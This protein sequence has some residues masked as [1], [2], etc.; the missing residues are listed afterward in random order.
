[1]HG[2][3]YFNEESDNEDPR[4]KNSSLSSYDVQIYE[5]EFSMIKNQLEFDD[6]NESKFIEFDLI[7]GDCYLCNEKLEDNLIIH[8]NDK[9]CLSVKATIEEFCCLICGEKLLNKKSFIKHQ[10]NL[11][12]IISLVTLN[13]L[14][15]Y[16][17]DLLNKNTQK[18]SILNTLNISEKMR[19]RVNWIRNQNRSKKNT[20]S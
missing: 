7:V 9:H 3:D 4:I 8:L 14:F 20:V 16:Q 5:T 2:G 13:K 12:N 1:M 17:D 19:E 6:L 11:H 18:F 15:K 10:F